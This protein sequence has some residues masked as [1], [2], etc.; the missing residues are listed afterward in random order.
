MKKGKLVWLFVWCI[1]LCLGMAGC[2]GYASSYSAT[3]LITENTSNS[4]SISFSTMK[5]SKVLQMKTKEEGKTL[6]YSGSLAEGKVT[7]YYD[8]DGS[9]KELFTLSGG[10]KAESSVKLNAKGK[11]YVIIETDGKCESGKFAFKIK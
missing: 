7:V 9:K 3:V 2:S 4:A 10:E 6:E 1:V 11:L 8:E 5:G